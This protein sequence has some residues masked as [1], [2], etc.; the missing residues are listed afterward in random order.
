MAVQSLFFVKEE[1]YLLKTLYLRG[2]ASQLAVLTL[3][4]SPTTHLVALKCNSA[5]ELVVSVTFNNIWQ[6]T[7]NVCAL[8]ELVDLAGM[9]STLQTH[10]AH[11]S[12]T[13]YMH[14]Y[15]PFLPFVSSSFFFLKKYLSHSYF[16]LSHWNWSTSIWLNLWW[17]P[18]HIGATFFWPFTL[19]VTVKN[20]ITFYH[21]YLNLYLFLSLFF[22]LSISCLWPFPSLYTFFYILH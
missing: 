2:K 12:I 15:E 17:N 13:V 7:A 4:N 18:I 11:G 16:P 6:T 8:H 14:I 22:P 19:T 10:W 9:N 3:N 1:L 5:W 20:Q 21:P